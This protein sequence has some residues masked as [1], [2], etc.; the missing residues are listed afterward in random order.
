[1]KVLQAGRVIQ[2]KSILCIYIISK[3]NLFIKVFLLWH[4]STLLYANKIPLKILVLY[5]D[6]YL[7]DWKTAVWLYYICCHLHWTSFSLWSLIKVYLC[8]K[9]FTWLFDCSYTR[10]HFRMNSQFTVCS[11]LT[12]GWIQEGM[13][14]P[15]VQ[16]SS[17][18]VSSIQFSLCC[19]KIFILAKWESGI[20]K[21]TGRNLILVGH[22]I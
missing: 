16:V 21:Y 3:L 9:H 7:D 22:T 20:H 15:T 18:Q 13:R 12:D 6:R 2:P 5:L 11:A 4:F 17:V 14:S 1:M 10:E 8:Y 19:L